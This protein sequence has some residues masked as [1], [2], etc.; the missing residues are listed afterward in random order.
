[1]FNLLPIPILDGGQILLNVAESIKGSALSAR[2]RE[3]ALRVGLLA[4][5]MLLVLVMFND[6]KSWLGL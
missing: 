4:I 3:Y 5:A 1:V 6:I 2:T